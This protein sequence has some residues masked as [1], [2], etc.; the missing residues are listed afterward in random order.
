MNIIAHP[1]PIRKSYRP[2]TGPLLSA[3]PQLPLTHKLF[4][5]NRH[6]KPPLSVIALNRI[7]FG[8]RP[9]DLA[10][11]N[12]LGQTDPERLETYVLQQI[13]PDHI[14]DTEFESRLAEANFKT[15]HKSLTSLWQEHY[16]AEGENEQR[17]LALREIERLT[18][19]RA[20]YSRKQLSELLAD[21]W[22]NHFNVDAWSAESIAAVFVHYD[23]DVIR[24]HQFGNFYELLKAVATSVE[25]IAYL[26]NHRN[27][28][29]SLDT[30]F[31][32]ALFEQHTLGSDHYLG[33]LRPFN[34]PR[35]Q[36]GFP[37]GFVDEDIAEAARCFTG[38]AF[39]ELTGAFQYRPDQHDYGHKSILGRLIGSK[40]P[41][42][43]DGLDVLRLLASHPATA[44]TICRK[45]CQRFI[46]DTPPASIV[47]SA[48][49][50]FLEQ[51]AAP[52]QLKQVVAHILLSD[53]FCQ[54]WG[55]KVKRPF[56]AI[57]SAMRITDADFDLAYHNRDGNSFMWRYDQMGQA[58]FPWH[59]PDGY[60]DTQSYWQGSTSL[61]MRWRLI[62]WLIEKRDDN[63]RFRLRVLEKTPTYIETAVDLVNYWI[64]QLLGYGMDE[65]DKQLIIDFIAQG[66]SPCAPI[67]LGNPHI[68]ER[69]RSMVAL[70]L[71]SPQYQLR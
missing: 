49:E 8:P 38:W 57:V 15:I 35:N 20:I 51:Q 18:F 6:T 66:D 58:P 43:Q 14:D 21:F 68:Q 48:T 26:E 40:Q 27:S 60:S 36:S 62:N 71:N 23:R 46:S 53:A 70:I 67:E 31:A 17:T 7:G 65:A 42:L 34:V 69:V 1:T 13:N 61:V 37:I 2:A 9:G 30:T 5:A 39:N 44:E 12:R 54:T 4:R 50:L 28:R 64:Q 63:G 33:Q 16:L 29:E 47:A 52:D 3:I 10:R 45:L 25:M 56:E 41:P 59:G 19:L 55:Q 22:H 24:Q 11:F 32:R